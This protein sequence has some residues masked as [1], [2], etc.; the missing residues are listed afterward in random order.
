MYLYPI[1]GEIISDITPQIAYETQQ[2]SRLVQQISGQFH[3]SWRDSSSTH[4][5]IDEIG[6]VHQTKPLAL[7]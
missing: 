1:S 4:A 3:Q 7:T 6:Q 2:I 5:H